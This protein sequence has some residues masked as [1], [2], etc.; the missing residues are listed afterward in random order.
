MQAS[1]SSESKSPWGSESLGSSAR[2]NNQRVIAFIIKGARPLWWL[3]VLWV[4]AGEDGEVY[5]S[6]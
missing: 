4:Q 3:W 1:T 2:Q 6:M 5:G